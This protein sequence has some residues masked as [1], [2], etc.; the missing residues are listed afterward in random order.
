MRKNV[1][2]FLVVTLAAGPAFA[3][4]TG[5]VFNSWA[6]GVF[7]PLIISNDGWLDHTLPGEP[8]DGLF[9]AGV[10]SHWV[11]NVATELE[12]RGTSTYVG[13]GIGLELFGGMDTV[14]FSNLGAHVWARPFGND[15]LRVTIGQFTDYTLRGWQ[16]HIAHGFEYFVLPNI[17]ELMY[18]ERDAIFQHFS[19]RPLFFGTPGYA[20]TQGF[21]LSSRPTDRLF[22]GVGVTAPLA[23]MGGGGGAWSRWLWEPHHVG[24]VYRTTQVAVAYTIPNIGFLRAQFLGGF[25]NVNSDNIDHF[26]VG[27]LDE[28]DTEGRDAR[29]ELGFAFTGVPN[30]L[31]DFGFKYHFPIRFDYGDI[32]YEDSNG[33]FLA[34]GAEYTFGDWRLR[35]RLEMDALRSWSGG[36]DYFNNGVGIGLRL[37]PAFDLGFG[38]VG[39]NIGLQ[40]RS[41]ASTNLTDPD[42]Q[43]ASL[44]IFGLGFGAFFERNFGNGLFKAGLAYTLPAMIGGDFDFRGPGVFSI[45]IVIEVWF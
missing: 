28:W 7:S 14:S 8:Q 45:P 33:I 22:L 39:L 30:L 25:M 34:V 5:I 24:V 18:D 40:Y 10:G 31:L 35:G 11:D 23:S 29:I 13:F 42:S 6:R 4:E 36:D 21:M 37:S 3:Q 2:L 44:S 32:N 41:E 15:L 9:G 38:M 12:I 43:M 20:H 1:L 17:I 27:D 19:Q 16:G 26:L